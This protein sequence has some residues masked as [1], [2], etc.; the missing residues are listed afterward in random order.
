MAGMGSALLPSRGSV[1]CRLA[2]QGRPK[3]HPIP[4]LPLPPEAGSDPV[5]L[6]WG[7]GRRLGLVSEFGLWQGLPDLSFGGE[8]LP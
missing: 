1:I 7:E 2:L 6:P 8:K 4:A 3:C 5:L